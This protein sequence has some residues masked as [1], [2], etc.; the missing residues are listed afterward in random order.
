VKGWSRA[1][2]KIGAQRQSSLLLLLRTSSLRLLPALVRT[3]S[4]SPLHQARRPPRGIVESVWLLH[5]RLYR[6][7]ELSAALTPR[8]CS[9][10]DEAAARTGD[11]PANGDQE[12]TALGLF[13]CKI[14]F[15]QLVPRAEAQ[16]GACGVACLSHLSTT[17][18]PIP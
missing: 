4:R 8:Q 1:R 14:Q 7:I 5:Q 17:S 6:L 9:M 18:S 2:I 13:L 16:S 11:L 3:W 10:P 15:Q 12:A